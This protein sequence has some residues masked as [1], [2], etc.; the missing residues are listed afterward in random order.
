[1]QKREINVFDYTQDI[2]QALRKGILVTT[3]GEDKVNPMVISWGTLGIEW[4]KPIFTTFI[5]TSRYTHEL[6]DVK[7]E[8]VVSIPMN[9]G[10]R[11]DI[12]KRCGFESGRDIDKVKECQ[13][14]LVDGEE[15]DVPGILEAPLTLECKVIYQQVQDLSA[16]KEEYRL[17]EY[18]EEV[19]G[20]HPLSN[21]HP[22]VAY[23][24]EIVKAYIIEE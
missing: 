9:G 24:G 13:L 23:Y 2:L 14:T 19:D 4:G 1:M 10:L 12:F 20:S 6:L 16:L 8:F 22:H 11:E 3:K 15:V 7:K 18:P 5:R 17:K 21:C